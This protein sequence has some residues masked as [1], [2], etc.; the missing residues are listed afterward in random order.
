MPLPQITTDLNNHQGLPDQPSNT[1][2]PSQLKALFDKAPN[3]IKTYLNS[4]LLPAIDALLTDIDTSS[5]I[6]KVDFF[7]MSTAPTGWLECN[8]AAVSRT[9]YSALFAKI[10]TLYGAGDGIN[11][12]NLPDLRGEFV[13]GWDH[14][15]GV[16][17]G[18]TL[19]SNQED[20]FKSHN[21]ALYGSTGG[22]TGGG[23]NVV[24]K[25][26]SSLASWA[27]GTVTNFATGSG[28]GNT[29]ISETR[30]RNVALLPCIRY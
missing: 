21:H 29:G 7:A 2:S 25:L 14:G 20:A 19:G 30:P 13:R 17:S 24:I 8:G 4:T 6:G 9:T 11:T 18:R 3:D 5:S 1:Y 15:R 16:D 23:G 28:M 10:G 12:F 26:L 27:W 22:E